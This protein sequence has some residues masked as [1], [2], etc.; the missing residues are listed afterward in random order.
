M[1]IT[2]RELLELAEGVGF[3]VEGQSVN[4]N[5]LDDMVTIYEDDS[6]SIW[7]SIAGGTIAMT[8][9]TA[10]ILVQAVGLEGIPDFFRWLKDVFFF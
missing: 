10:F 1:Q 4:E 8:A 5:Q 9:F 7:W 6:P 2:K 3:D